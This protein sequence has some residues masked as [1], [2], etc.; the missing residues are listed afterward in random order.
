MLG[1]VHLMTMVNGMASTNPGTSLSLR[2]EVKSLEVRHTDTSSAFIDI[3]LRMELRNTGASPLIFLKREPLFVGAALAR[4]PADFKLGNVLAAD[5]VWPAVSIAPE[6]TTLRSTLD[7]PQPPESETRI[8]MPGDSWFLE[9]SVGV[10]V[11][12]NSKRYTSLGSTRRKESLAAI[13][14]LSPVWL[15]VT[16]EVWPSNVE[17]AGSASERAKLHF[18]HTLQKR[19][20]QAGL[21]WL[22]TIH[23]EPITLDLWRARK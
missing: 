4:E 8:L 3:D 19:W 13:Q 11:P 21:L 9:A 14:Q 16:C 17:P 15:R 10:T 23:S 2:G 22:D 5:G 6:W 1:M 20:A 12:T 18:G 7:Q